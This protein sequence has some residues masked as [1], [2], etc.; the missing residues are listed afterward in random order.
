[1]K[2]H[3]LVCCL[4]F[5]LWKT[6]AQLCQRAELGKEPRKVFQELT[7]IALVDVVLPTRNRVIMGKRRISSTN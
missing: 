4:A 3:I 6:L 2:A 7:D 5:V 1:V